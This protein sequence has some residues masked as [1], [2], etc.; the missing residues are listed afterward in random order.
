MTTE[1]N[2]HAAHIAGPGAH[3]VR[4]QKFPGSGK[5]PGASSK[6]YDKARGSRWRAGGMMILPGADEL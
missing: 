4:R 6:L 3:A 2:A 1:Q 5:H